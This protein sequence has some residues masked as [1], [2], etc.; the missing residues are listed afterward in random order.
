ML[1]QLAPLLRQAKASKRG[2]PAKPRPIFVSRRVELAYTKALLKLVAEMHSDTISQLTPLIKPQVGDSLIASD[3]LLDR[4]QLTFASL[5][6]SIKTKINLI[7]DKL[8]KNIVYQQQKQSDKQLVD[9]LKKQTGLDFTGLLRDEVL[10]DALNEAIS[11]NVALIKSIPEQ[12]LYRV[13]QAVM[14]GVQSGQLNKTLADELQKIKNMTDNRAKLIAADQLGKINSRLTQIRQQKLGVTHYTWSTSHDERVR[15]EHRLRDGKLFAWDNPP[16]D[17][18]AGQAIR[19]RCVALPYTEHLYGGASPDAVMAGQNKLIGEQ[20][21]DKQINGTVKQQI[22]AIDRVFANSHALLTD[23]SGTLTRMELPHSADGAKGWTGGI[24]GLRQSE[25]I[26]RRLQAKGD[27][28]PAAWALHHWSIDSSYLVDRYRKSNWIK[29]ADRQAMAE[30]TST[31]QNLIKMLFA[32]KRA[33]IQ[34]PIVLYRG[35]GLPKAELDFIENDLHQGKYSDFYEA[36]LTSNT[37]K[38]DL[39]EDFAISNARRTG[40]IPVIHKTFIKK[41]V[42][43]IDITAL[44]Y[45]DEQEI[46]L[47]NDLT[48]EIVA[49]QRHDNGSVEL[50]SIISP[51]NKHAGDSD[52]NGNEWRDVN[53]C[54]PDDPHLNKVSGVCASIR[55]GG[56]LSDITL[57]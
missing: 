28:V 55:T 48:R 41:G 26:M 6:Q 23:N 49:M 37:L 57:D 19:C 4:F 10:T 22:D 31:A 32:D 54:I 12:Y 27:P 52:K 24:M 17:G 46:L 5:S 30:A 7:A 42:R 14:A 44:N 20:T 38:R 11:A 21:L 18:H 13:E 43:G 33:V 36:A 39:A 1:K 16:A 53:V 35:I 25:K 40:G 2:R 29:E 8:A 47:E 34:E 15:H 45:Y 56:K 51:K 3:G 50:T 9:I